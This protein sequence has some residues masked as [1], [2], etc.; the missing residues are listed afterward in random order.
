MRSL[1]TLHIWSTK[2]DRMTDDVKQAMNKFNT[3][4][5]TCKNVCN[6]VFTYTGQNIF[7]RQDILSN[8]LR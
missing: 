7:S 2:F 3:A 4:A 8:Y 6:K 1:C 5:A